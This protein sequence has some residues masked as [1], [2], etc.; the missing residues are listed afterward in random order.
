MIDLKLFRSLNT[1]ENCKSDSFIN[2]K[3]L[4]DMVFNSESS[5]TSDPIECSFNEIFVEDVN[6]VDSLKIDEDFI[7][8]D[9]ISS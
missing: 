9:L 1:E 4:S 3:K 7:K 5:I 6:R 8:N 2:L